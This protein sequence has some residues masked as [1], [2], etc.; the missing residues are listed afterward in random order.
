MKKLVMTTIAALGLAAVSPAVAQGPGV[1]LSVGKPGSGPQGTTTT[2]LFGELVRVSGELTNGQPNQAIDLTVT[3]YRGEA[4]TVALRTDSQGEFEYVHRPAIRTSYSA[5]FGNRA[6]NQEPYAHVRPKIGLRVLNARRGLFRITMAAR[7]EHVSRV[8]FMQRRIGTEWHTIRRVRL[9][10]RNLSARFRANLPAGV[11]RV[12]MITP[13][14]P[15]YLGGTSR[16]VR[17]RGF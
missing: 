3:P 7:P 4:R 2:V 8:A 10:A 1:N 14:T 15:G 17:V 13:Q 5:R 12:R 16:F 6:S 11:H 9:R